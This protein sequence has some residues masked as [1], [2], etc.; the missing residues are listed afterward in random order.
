MLNLLR[1]VPSLPPWGECVCAQAHAFVAVHCTN[2]NGFLHFQL[3][4]HNILGPSFLA[5][6]SSSGIILTTMLSKLITF[7]KHLKKKK[8]CAC[9]RLC[10]FYHDHWC[11]NIASLIL[12]SITFSSFVSLFCECQRTTA[13]QQNMTSAEKLVC[14]AISTTPLCS[15]VSPLF[16]YRRSV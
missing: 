9:W 12:H 13:Q 4:E 8:N 10:R 2:K 1:C 14:P 7:S 6:L 16:I 3:W 5:D 11:I 15:S